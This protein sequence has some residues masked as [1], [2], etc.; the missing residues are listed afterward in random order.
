M[1]KI[2][3]W[4]TALLIAI[5]FCACDT[6]DKSTSE[7]KG[8]GSQAES[9]TG[10]DG[11]ENG[12]VNSDTGEPTLCVVV[13]DSA[14]GSFVETQTV[15]VG[16]KLVKP[17]NPTKQEDGNYEYTFEA[18]YVGDYEWNFETDRV[19]DN[20]TLTAKWNAELIFT[21]PFLPSD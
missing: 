17:A 21:S 7:S 16:E 15:A 5:S 14:G 9:S 10:L 18:W 6:G 1:R 13:F 3:L 8:N 4:F 11:G 20:M 12:G 2:A 19:S